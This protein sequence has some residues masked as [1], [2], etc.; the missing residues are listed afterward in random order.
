MI[1]Q[2]AMKSAHITGSPE[3]SVR[4]AVTMMSKNK[5]GSLLIVDDGKLVGI[6][7][8][9]DV[10]NKVVLNTKNPENMEVREIMS[11]NPI[12]ISKDSPADKRVK[13]TSLLDPSDRSERRKNRL[14]TYRKC[15]CKA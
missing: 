6:M 10:L 2:E 8:E 7:T 3:M 13:L 15:L 14:L 12:T 9:R 1:V 5:V 11:T 4:D